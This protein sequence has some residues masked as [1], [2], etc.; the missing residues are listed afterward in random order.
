MDLTQKFFFI[1]KKQILLKAL[2]KGYHAYQLNKVKV[3]HE[4]GK[5]VYDQEEHKTNS[6]I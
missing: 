2:K 4:K 3:I 5:A 6:F 1:G